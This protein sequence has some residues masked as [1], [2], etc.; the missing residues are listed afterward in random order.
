MIM[1]IIEPRTVRVTGGSCIIRTVEESDAPAM[2]ELMLHM[3]RTAPFQV[4]EPDEGMQTVEEVAA[5]GE[6]EDESAPYR[7]PRRDS[8]ARV[9]LDAW[10]VESR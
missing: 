4:R 2:L 7:L 9:L 6:W 8:I 3:A 10:V 1:A 5:F